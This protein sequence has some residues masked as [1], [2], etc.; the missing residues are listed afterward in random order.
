MAQDETIYRFRDLYWVE[1][2]GDTEN[3]RVIA[4]LFHTE[5]EGVLAAAR[6]SVYFTA[7]VD[8]VLSCELDE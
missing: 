6:V 2:Q 1:A 4:G 7:D 5:K 8:G 3:Q